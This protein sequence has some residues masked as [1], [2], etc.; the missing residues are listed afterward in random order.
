LNILFV[1]EYYVPHIG[2]A[3]VLFGNLCQGLV[4]RGHDVTV[5]TLRLPDTPSFE[6]ID[7]V[8]VHRLKVPN[9]GGRY[10]FTFLAVPKALRLARQA[11]LIHT[12]T[13]NGAFPAWLAGRLGRRMCVITVHELLGRQWKDLAGMGALNARLHQLLERLIIALPFR[14]YIAVSRYTADCLRSSG[15]NQARTTVIYNGIDSGLFSPDKSDGQPVRQK[16][17]LNG[18]FVYMYYGRPG[19]SKGVEY[20]VQAVPLIRK[21]LPGS[22]LLMILA[23]DPPD[24]YENIRRMMKDLASEGSIIL[25]S[26]VPRPEL[27]GYIAAADCVVVPSLSEGF[28]F[29]AAEACAMGRPVVASNVAS[30]PEVVSGRYVLVAPRDPQALAEGVVEICR[31]EGETSQPKVFSWD[32]CVDEYLAIYEQ[33]TGRSTR[34]ARL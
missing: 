18:E 5:L 11:D 32:R 24:R 6:V 34:P 22:K 1:L 10:W 9:K 26:P 27:P 14:R 21:S 7:G 23:R 8:K 31:G 29:A 30:L 12:T 16:L 17:K 13:Y 19:V 28:G 33:T 3:E 15:V 2:G 20:L 4:A 25:L